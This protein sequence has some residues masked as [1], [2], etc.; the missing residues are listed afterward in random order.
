MRTAIDV[1]SVV[2]DGTR[3]S[4]ALPD[5]ERPASAI[6]VRT[7]CSNTRDDFVGWGRH[8]HPNPNSGEPYGAETRRAVAIQTIRHGGDHP[9]ALALPVRQAEP[10]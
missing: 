10:A 6:P 4:C 5:D 3:L 7:P 1:A 8:Y 9:S 2:R